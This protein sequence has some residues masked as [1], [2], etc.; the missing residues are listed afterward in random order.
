ML[1]LQHWIKKLCD[2]SSLPTNEREF[3]KKKIRVHCYLLNELRQERRNPKMTLM[4]HQDDVILR[5]LSCL[6]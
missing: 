4:A 1:G 5:A 2:T 6:A 3:I